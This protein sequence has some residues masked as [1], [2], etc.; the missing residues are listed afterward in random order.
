VQ[1][2]EQSIPHFIENGLDF[3]D[4]IEVAAP[5]PYAIVS[6]TEDM[7]PFE[8]AKHTVEGAKRWYALYDLADRIR[9]I[10]GPGGHGALTPVHPQILAFFTKY[11][12]RSDAT[13]TYTHLTPDKPADLFCT[14]DG[15]VSGATISEIISKRA[16]SV[17]ITEPAPDC[18]RSPAFRSS[19][20]HRSA[21]HPANYSSRKTRAP[22]RIPRYSLSP[23]TSPRICPLF[24]G[25][26]S[27]W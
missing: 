13:P 16:D 9:W 26:E 11:L 1:E 21:I 3:A 19:P 17:H 10:T 20:A 12:K 22:G 4:W 8:G 25:A 2:A 18:R 15:P 27:Y 6:T 14:P 24:R 7:F 23:A 5:K